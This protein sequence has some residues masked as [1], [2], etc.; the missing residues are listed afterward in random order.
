MSNLRFAPRKTDTVLS[1]VIISTGG[2]VPITKCPPAKR[3]KRGF[4]VG[5]SSRVVKG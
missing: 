3:G 4:T 1:L 5:K 2:N